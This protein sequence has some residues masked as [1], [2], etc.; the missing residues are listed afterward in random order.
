MNFPAIEKAFT[1]A[2]E[3][4]RRVEE[5][6]KEKLARQLSA[7]AGELKAFAKEKLLEIVAE[8]TREK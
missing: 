5:E 8:L 6:S 7:R 3:A 2:K 1:E 4:L